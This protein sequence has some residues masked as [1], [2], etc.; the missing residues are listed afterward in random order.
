[1]N[2]INQY[3]IWIADLNPTYGSEPGKIRPMIIMQA[4]VL[5]RANHTS[6]IACAISSQPREGVTLLRVPLQPTATN[7]LQKQ[8]YILCDQIRAIDVNRLHERVGKLDSEVIEKLKESIKV[9]LGL[10]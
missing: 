1:M 3:E 9:I 2:K 7:G 4:D 6:T 8:S 5:H 10:Y